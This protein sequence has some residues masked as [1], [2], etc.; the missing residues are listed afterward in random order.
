MI[1]LIKPLLVPENVIPVIDCSVL[2]EAWINISLDPKTF[3]VIAFKP[4]LGKKQHVM[5]LWI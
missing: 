3:L 1:L 4:I 2:D 5:N